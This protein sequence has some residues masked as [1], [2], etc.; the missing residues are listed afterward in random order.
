M[1]TEILL[2]LLQPFVANK[3]IIGDYYL[4]RTK[5]TKF[6][7]MNLLNYTGSAKKMYTQ[8]NRWYL[9][10]VSEVELNYRMVLKLF[11]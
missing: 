7:W 10:S 8:F 6:Y 5:I 1:F 2:F 11:L 9:C 3:A 4:E